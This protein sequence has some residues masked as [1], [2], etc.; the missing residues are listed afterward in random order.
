[1]HGFFAC[2]RIVH[3]HFL[4]RLGRDRGLLLQSVDLRAQLIHLGLGLRGQAFKTISE[5]AANGIDGVQLL[6]QRVD[7][8]SSV[9]TLRR[10]P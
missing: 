8:R 6:R 3:H 2:I 7:S 1:M 10:L 4:G 5:I 9:R